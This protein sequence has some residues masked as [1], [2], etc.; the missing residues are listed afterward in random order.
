[1]GYKRGP[2]P[3]PPSSGKPGVTPSSV[4]FL[5]LG[6]RVILYTNLE[7][8]CK[9]ILSETTK[10]TSKT[11]YHASPD[12]H[13]RTDRSQAHTRPRRRRLPSAEQRPKRLHQQ[14]K[15]KRTRER[16]HINAGP[17]QRYGMMRTAAAS[18]HTE[19]AQTPNGSNTQPCSE[20]QERC[21][22]A[23]FRSSSA[24]RVL[25]LYCLFFSRALPGS[26]FASPPSLCFLYVHLIL[27]CV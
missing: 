17:S 21:V 5:V 23:I 13:Q 11:H 7:W 14:N 12:H 26:L 15:K 24:V 19:L 25:S 9:L 18:T 27:N 2:P 4:P 1:M 8:K 22:V 3:K 20:V 16:Q 10:T 6:S